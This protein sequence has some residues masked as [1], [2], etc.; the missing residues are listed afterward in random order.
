M[1]RWGMPVV[2]LPQQ[3]RGPAGVRAN[4]LAWKC[5]RPRAGAAPA[6]PHLPCFLT[7]SWGTTPPSHGP[8]CKCAI[9]AKSIFRLCLNTK[10]FPSPPKWRPRTT[11]NAGF[12]Q[13]GSESPLLCQPSAT[14]G[15]PGYDHSRC[16]FH[17]LT[18]FSGRSLV[19]I[20]GWSLQFW[21]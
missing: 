18:T 14:H 13:M 7:G 5:P 20:C 9:S 1:K 12:R 10:L 21:I 19:G 4:V 11:V 17:L 8:G 3:Q 16:I 15:E 6:A 2:S